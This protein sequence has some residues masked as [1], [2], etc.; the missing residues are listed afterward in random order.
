MR[1]L[2]LFTAAASVIAIGRPQ[3]PPKQPRPKNSLLAKVFDKGPSL[4]YQG[5]RVVTIKRRSGEQSYREL[6]LKSGPNIKVKFFGATEV[7]GQIIVENSQTRWHYIP[8]RNEI[9]ESPAR[10]EESLMFLIGPMMMGGGGIQGGQNSGRN[11]GGRREGGGQ[12]GDRPGQRFEPSYKETDG[13]YIAGQRTRLLT[14]SDS[15]SK[16]QL[17]KLWIEPLHGVILKRQ[18]FGPRGEE[19]G[20]FEFKTINFQPQFPASTFK[21]LSIAGAKK[22]TVEDLLKDEAKKLGVKPY[23]LQGQKEYRLLSAR[24]F[25]QD[26]SKVLMMVYTNGQTRVTLFQ[27]KGSFDPKRFKSEA[28]RFASWTWSL[29]GVNFAIVGSLEQS[30]LQNL[31]KLVKA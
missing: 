18:A 8:G 2:L 13:D 20:G 7:N 1:T 19:L 4:T 28:D 30:K 15:A 23:R 17:I 6:I 31:A 9:R 24:G 25:S 22:V 29:D 27:V 3:D 5:E 12:G 10:R 26:K 11:G 21:P 16:K 14:L